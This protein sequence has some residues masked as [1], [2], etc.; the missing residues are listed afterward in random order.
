MARR[1]LEITQETKLR[2]GFY[3]DI[4]DAVRVEV[5]EWYKGVGEGIGGKEDPDT[6]ALRGEDLLRVESAKGVVDI[7]AQGW[8]IGARLS[9]ILI[10]TDQRVKI[11]LRKEPLRLAI[12]EVED[13]RPES[14]AAV[15]PDIQSPSPA[16]PLART[17]AED[18]GVPLPEK[19]GTVR[20]SDVIAL[21]TQRQAVISKE[22]KIEPGVLAAPI[23]RQRA[24]EL[25]VDLASVKGFG[26]EGVIR[27]QDL[28]AHV[29]SNLA[30]DK[31]ETHN[32]PQPATKGR[33]I[34]P[35][36]RH[37]LTAE[38]MKKAWQ[39]PLASPGI[40][41]DPLPLLTLRGQMREDFEK[42]HGIK[43]R[44]DYF[45]ITACAW[46]LKQPEFHILNARCIESNDEPLIECYPHVNIGI[47]VAIAPHVTKNGISEL[48]TP[49]ILA[50]EEKS[51]V[52]I[53]C[54][55]D[56]LIRE[57]AA[58]KPLAQDQQGLTFI[59]NNVGSPVMWRGMQFAG[60]EDPDPIPAPDTCALLAFGTV[61]EVAGIK[62]MKLRLRFDHR[63]V[64]G[65]EP[66]MF[67][68]ALQFLLER[69]QQ[70][71]VF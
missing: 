8:E 39:A 69:P 31:K 18:I 5:M 4:T 61:R 41:I 36:I 46:L 9:E 12:L 1:F 59:V 60:D 51:L 42:L 53:A 11:D 29:A 40:D 48:V 6:G 62:R 65:Y 45:I 16:T 20:L 17:L 26:P 33:L 68:R 22:E 43:L 52:E 55:A 10:P 13:G 27:L 38:I 49:V 63:V 19:E 30:L 25:G 2:L 44:I 34:R 50:A 67:V 24:K 14:S 57:A 54:Y 66:K 23:V 56:R 58:G 21:N 47:A 32:A 7:V 71:A 15:F 64:N 37:I 70:I 3:M 28:D 35:S